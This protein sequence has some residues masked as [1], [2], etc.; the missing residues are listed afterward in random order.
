MYIYIYKH[1]TKAYFCSFKIFESCS[2]L[3]HVVCNIELALISRSL[4]HALHKMIYSVRSS[5][6]GEIIKR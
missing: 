3:D 2:K 1:L 6:F 4:L 5:I